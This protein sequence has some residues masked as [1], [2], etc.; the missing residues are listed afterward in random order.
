MSQDV[1][2]LKELLFE[3]ESR[4]LADLNQRMDIV[5]ER[6][7]STEQ[8]TASVASVLDD[9]LAQAEIERHSEVASAIAPLIVQTI[10]TEIRGSQ[11]E[12]AEALYPSMGRMVAAYVVSAIRDLMDEINRRLESNPYMLRLR[13]VLTG[14]PMAELAFVEGQRLRVDELYLIRRGLGQ[15]IGHWPASNGPT[16][17]D[18]RVSGILTAINEVANEAFD[19]DKA[20]LRRIDLG[21]SLIYL[22]ASPTHL[23][24][25]KCR[26]VAPTS[27]EKIIDA[28]FLSTI[29]RLRALVN[30]GTDLSV[31][32]RAVNMLLAE[33]A[34]NLD[35]A[36]AE[37]HAKLSHRRTFVSPALVLVWGIGLALAAWLAWGAYAGYQTARVRGIA[38]DVLAKET[39]LAGYPV[40]AVVERRGRDVA[41][42]GLVPTAQAGESALQNLRAALPG[43]EVADRTTALPTGLD[44]ARAD[45]AALQAE[46][47]RARTE[48]ADADR[49]L[50]ERVAGLETEMKGEFKSLAAQ[51]GQANANA[52]A[53]IGG[54]RTALSLAETA[55]RAD[56]GALRSEIARAVAPTPLA[57]L[58]TW[59]RANAVFFAKDT[60]YRDQQAAAAKLDELAALIND[61]D[62]LV[63]VVGYTDEKGGEERNTPLSQA[64]AE[65]VMAE[66]ST[67]GIAAPRLVAVGRKNSA[68]LSMM[69]GD[70]SPNRRVEFEIG[71]DGEGPP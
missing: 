25:A 31:P 42:S 11:D 7:G 39:A 26:G 30:G 58:R 19:A 61:T 71:F 41:L 36:I 51:L 34:A 43:S 23:V 69:V 14:R 21:T 63:R 15:S 20:A 46:L 13:S 50:Q 32:N 2:R 53:G 27:V 44:A 38:A 28:Q 16:I 10:K 64:R 47:A 57:R 6:A 5:F 12:L 33:L 24:A 59:T 56:L 40:R 67:R 9:A 65:K 55:R 70:A 18:Q 3:S 60:D 52:E 29:E 8:F 45:I 66:L 22:R 37:Q 35:G 1:N 4:A 54:L 17:Q 48:S 62:V 49:A 68:D